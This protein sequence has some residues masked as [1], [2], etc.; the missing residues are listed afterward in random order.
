MKVQGGRSRFYCLGSG[1]MREVKRLF[2]DYKENIIAMKKYQEQ[3]V[4]VEFIKIKSAKWSPEKVDGG[5]VVKE[6]TKMARRIDRADANINAIK[7]I[8]AD[9][10]PFLLAMNKISEEQKSLLKS[11]YMKCRSVNE[12]ANEFDLALSM[13]KD[14]LKKAEQRFYKLYQKYSEEVA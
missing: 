1:M 7:R 3:Q 6:D 13:T 8:K 10:R 12:V 5:K 9:L 4:Q 11:R 14:R 2:E